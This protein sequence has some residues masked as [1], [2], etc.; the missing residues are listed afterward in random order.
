MLLYESPP[1]K[2]LM[3]KAYNIAGI[4]NPV[5]DEIS[6]EINS[7]SSKIPLGMT[8]GIA[9]SPYRRIVVTPNR[10]ASLGVIHIQPFRL[11]RR[12]GDTVAPTSSQ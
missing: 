4:K 7:L 5:R 11:G 8:C 12:D 6:V 2:G 10:F 1:L 3:Q 9:V